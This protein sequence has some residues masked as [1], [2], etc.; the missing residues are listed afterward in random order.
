MNVFYDLV[1][2]QAVVDAFRNEY[3]HEIPHESL[4]RTPSSVCFAA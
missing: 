3:N 2:A 1:H 4:K